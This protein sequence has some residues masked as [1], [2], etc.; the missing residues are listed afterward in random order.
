MTK[1]FPDEI[2]NSMLKY[3]NPNV[4]ADELSKVVIGQDE[5]VR[6][7][8]FIS[9]QRDA[10]I[11]S[12][13]DTGKTIIP[14][15]L[16][17]S[18]DTGSGKTFMFEKLAEIVKAPFLRVDIT[19]YTQ[20]GYKGKDVETL[21]KT[22]HEMATDGRGGGR[23]IVLIDEIDKITSSSSGDAWH[24]HAVLNELLTALD[25]TRSD[26]DSDEMAYVLWVFAGS[27]ATYRNDKRN[28]SV[29]KTIG[30]N[31]NIESAKGELPAMLRADYIKAGMSPEFVGRIGHF[32]T[33]NSVD[34]EMLTNIL[35]SEQSSPLKDVI[36]FLPYMQDMVNISAEN[37]AE[38][39]DRALS[40]G[41]GV[42]GLRIATEEVLFNARG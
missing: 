36:Y 10:C 33:M 42:R 1:F 11:L 14:S 29:K 37:K 13:F 31:G 20:S 30:F 7:A 24:Q 21:I 16:L 17:V 35:E 28:T 38:I 39:L 23:L 18:G 3:V 5:A 25:N 26:E 19:H 22:I 32:A 40:M 6:K 4:L 34:R 12:R 27:F 15:K 8:A 9:A 41:I 2:L